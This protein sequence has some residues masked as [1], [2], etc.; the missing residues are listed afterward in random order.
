VLAVLGDP[1]RLAIVRYLASKEGVPLNCSQFLDLGSKTNLSYHLAKLREAGVTRAEVV[2]TSRLITLRRDDLAREALTRRYQAPTVW[3]AFLHYLSRE[4]YAV[5]PTLL[6]R[7]VTG[8][9]QPSSEVQQILVDLYRRDPKNAELCERLVDLDEGLQEWRYR[10][11]KMVERTIGM[12]PG[13][14]GSSG[15]AYLATT[16]G[17]PLFPDLWQIRGRL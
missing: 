13:T 9:P 15:A 17:T 6:A 5:P 3:D 12:K 14:G 16:V 4:G 10:H 1:T 8:P 7:D 2:G 11:V